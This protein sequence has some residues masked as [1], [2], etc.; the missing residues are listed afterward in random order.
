MSYTKTNWENSPSTKTPLNAENLNN[1]EAGVSALHEAL[2]AGTLKGE[3]GDQGEKG[4][5]GEKGTKGDAG[6]GIKKITAS[7]EGNVVT[8]TIELT[9]GTKQ[10][11]SFEV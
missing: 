1:I 5:K 4:D 8:L 7:K 10:T 6:V 11:P 2:D 9:D 3:K